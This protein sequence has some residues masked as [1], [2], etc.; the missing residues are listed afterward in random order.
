MELHAQWLRHSWRSVYGKTDE[1]GQTVVEGE[2]NAGD[3]FATIF[4]ALGI[5]HD[6]EYMVGSRPIPIS[7][8]GSTAVSRGARMIPKNLK[9]TSEWNSKI[10]CFASP[11]TRK[12]RE[13]GLARRISTS[14]NLTT[15][16]EKPER[17]AFTGDGHESYVTGIVQVGKTLVTC[18]YDRRLVWWDIE[19]RR[20]IRRVA[21]HDKWIRAIV[22]SPINRE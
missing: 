22:A 8:F 9:K 6:K 15:A 12:V 18:G 14:T 16:Q 7:D 21:A 4:A 2:M 1:D 17:T 20:S 13:F 11:R 10:S 3:L 5:E 19:S